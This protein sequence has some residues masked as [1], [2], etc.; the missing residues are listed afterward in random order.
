MSSALS[1]T[2]ALIARPSVTPDDAGC[3]ALLGQR[4]AAAGFVNERLDSGPDTFRVSNLWSLRDVPGAPTLVF[5]GHTDVVPTGPM[6]QW[7]SDPFTPTHRDG[8]LFGRG[9]SDMKTSIAAMVVAAEEFLAACA[10]PAFS[11]GFCSPATKKARLWM[12]PR[13]CARP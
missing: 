4:L 9:A 1:L 7:A 10:K 13:W 2:E 12:A 8:K 6:E 3:L 5:A 11:I